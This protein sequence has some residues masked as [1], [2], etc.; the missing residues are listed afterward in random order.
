MNKLYAGGVATRPVIAG[1]KTKLTGSEPLVNTIGIVAVAAFAATAE[2]LS[3]A[4]S[5]TTWRPTSSV[6]SA[7]N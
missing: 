1:D 6:A 7:G 4:T 5:I 2:G 3:V